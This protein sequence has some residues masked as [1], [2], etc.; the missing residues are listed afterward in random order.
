MVMPCSASDVGQPPQQQPAALGM[1]HAVLGRTG[2]P[3]P[4][5]NRAAGQRHHAAYVGHDPKVADRP[6]GPAPRRRSSRRTGTG[7]RLVEMP[8]PQ[9]ARWGSRSRDGLDP[10]DAGVVDERRGDDPSRRSPRVGR[11]RPRTGS[12]ATSRT[13]ARVRSGPGRRC[14]PH[15]HRQ[16][17]SRLGPTEENTMPRDSRGTA[18]GLSVWQAIGISVALMAPS[19]AANINPQGTAGLVG[20][21]TPLA[22]FLAA[23]AVLLIAYVF[24]RLCQYYQHAGSVYVFAGAT[25]GAA[26]GAIA[27]LGLLGTYTFYGLVTASAAGVFGARSSTRSASGTTSRGGPGSWSAAWRCCSCSGSRSC[28]RDA[29]PRPADHRGRHGAAHPG[30]RAV[31]VRQDGRRQRPPATPTSPSTSSRSNR[32]PTPRPSSSGSSSACCRSPASRRP[33]R[34]ARRRTTPAATS[35]AP[36]SAPRSSAASTSPSSRPWR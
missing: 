29:R 23:V 26:A 30:G 20:R 13:G 18:S 31:R 10:R 9:A 4:T 5:P 21:A 14:A 33:R 15:S 2:R 34:S 12:T 32:A 3:A 35:R 1:R 36:S 19:M 28:P 7:R 16:P 25:L 22:F 24:V 11:E 6:R 27:G 8:T 17:H